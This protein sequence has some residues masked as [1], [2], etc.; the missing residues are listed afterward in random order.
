MGTVHRQRAGGGFC[1]SERAEFDVGGTGDVGLVPF[2]VLAHVE[3]AFVAVQVGE[4]DQ[5]DLLEIA[6]GVLPG[7][8]TT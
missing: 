2:V 1:C 5:R 4:A 8:H 3:Q 7:G 6:S